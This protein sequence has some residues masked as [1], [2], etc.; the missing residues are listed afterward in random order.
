MKKIHP[1]K[2]E[3]W[4]I[5]QPPSWGRCGDGGPDSKQLSDAYPSDLT[6]AVLPREGWLSVQDTFR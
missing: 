1:A 6:P 4:K 3:A 2:R 5:E